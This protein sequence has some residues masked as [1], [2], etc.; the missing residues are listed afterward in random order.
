VKWLCRKVEKYAESSTG[1]LCI[2]E[3]SDI[4]SKFYRLAAYPGRLRCL[5]KVLQTGCVSW[6]VVTSAQ[7]STDWL[8]ILEACDVCSKFYRLAVYPGRL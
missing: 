4:C 5:L 8:C 2:L 6:Q 1:W 7:S 3:G